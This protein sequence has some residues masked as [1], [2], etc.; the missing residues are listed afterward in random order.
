[1]RAIVFVPPWPSQNDLFFFRNSFVRHLLPQAMLLLDCGWEVTIVV[2]D[3]LVPDLASLQS[4]GSKVNFVVLSHADAARILGSFKDPSASL[5]EHHLGAPENEAIIAWLEKQLPPT[6]DV[7]TLWEAPVPYLERMYPEALFLHQMPGFFARPPYPHTVVFDPVGLFRHGAMYRFADQIKAQRHPAGIDVVRFKAECRSLIRRAGVFQ[8]RDINPSGQFARTALLPLQVSRHYTFAVDTELTSQIELL[9]RVLSTTL[10]T[11]GVVVTQYVAK[12]IKECLSPEEIAYLQGRFPNLIHHEYFNTIP[13]VSQHLLPVVDEVITASSSIGMQ[14]L[15]WDLPVSV[16]GETHLS[17]YDQKNASAD[18]GDALSFA[19]SRHQPLASDVLTNKTF[20]P[21]L[22]EE[23]H[24][25]RKNAGIDRL[26]TF[27]DIDN[28]YQERLFNSFRGDAALK[29]LAKAGY[30]KSDDRT[31]KKYSDAANNKD[32]SILSFDVFD[33]LVT[34]PLEAPADV[35]SIL[36]K[37]TGDIIGRHIT[38]FADI[39]M[40]SELHARTLIEKDGEITLD[41]IYTLL[42]KA[43]GLTDLDTSR[44]KSAEIELEV[45]LAQVRPSGAR[46]WA[47][48]RATGKSIVCVSDMYHPVD[49]V[50]RILEK[51]GFSGYK[52]LYVS[53]THGKTKSS[54]EL[55]DHLVADLQVEPKQI[56]HLGDNKRTDIDSGT[57][58]GLATF[59]VAKALDIMRLNP[60]YKEVFHPQPPIIHLGRSAVVGA[61]ARTFHDRPNTRSN[62]DLFHEGHFELGY[63][64]L[65]PVL[66]GYVAWLRRDAAQRGLSHLY[67][68]SRE[69][70]ILK[71]IFDAMEAARPSGLTSEYLFGSRRLIRIAGIKDVTQVMDVA[72]NPI[73]NQMT[74]GELLSA[75]F[76]LSPSQVPLDILNSAGYSSLD[77]VVD[78]AFAGSQK[79]VQLAAA[80]ADVIIPK[81]ANERQVYLDY[82]SR[83][84]IPR[85]DMALVDIG[86]NANMQGSLGH[87]LG[88]PLIGYYYATMSKARKWQYTGHEIHSYMA[89]FAQTPHPSCMLSNRLIA[90]LLV[91][92][93]RGS[94][95]GL[96]QD[97]TG[98]FHP[99]RKEAQNDAPRRHMARAVHEGVMAFTAD[100]L[101][102]FG[103]RVDDLDIDPAFA[104]RLLGKFLA[105]PSPKDAE[106]LS[107]I[108]IEDSFGGVEAMPLINKAALDKSYW[109]AGGEALR[110]AMPS[111]A[112]SNA[113]PSAPQGSRV[114][115]RPKIA[116]A[117]LK[118]QVQNALSAGHAD[119]AMA[120]VNTLLERGEKDHLFL[121]QAADEIDKLGQSSDALKILKQVELFL[122]DNNNLKKRIAELEQSLKGE[123]A[124]KEQPKATPPKNTRQKNTQQKSAQGKNEAGGYLRK[125]LRIK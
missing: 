109:K 101:A 36:E 64:A 107:E 115:D 48:A 117:D 91:C 62:L 24:G 90:E 79:F 53:S 8:S 119:T 17:P 67:F 88:R 97:D 86:W 99:L 56:L 95:V 54:G 82:L 52:Q 50:R 106:L 80:L 61:I 63:A 70:L 103:S 83:L 31:A 35:W 110:D 81:A 15:V 16:V 78:G 92:E 27:T 100:I 21:A 3:S 29:D 12:L 74:I 77:E 71:R 51:C 38:N 116:S 123:Q 43:C 111:A 98:G 33:T 84:G 25:R 66:F 32:I 23:L 1:M 46:L 96:L 28:S 2:G 19:L 93:E 49:V 125:L 94:I 10:D 13:S 59:R 102:A 4:Y 30:G 47:I 55:F 69:G 112:K 57:A 42:Q 5:Y 87:L 6:A 41:D 58:R 44:L 108:S 121:R 76:N 39:R 85:D 122:P 105:E 45:S 104:E 68:L 113:A 89:H 40:R 73:S 14:A 120:A 7:I 118:R 37:D 72:T 65:A 9:L 114:E 22:I 34:R 26:A 20:L 18:T 75:R 11:T 124:Q 60:R